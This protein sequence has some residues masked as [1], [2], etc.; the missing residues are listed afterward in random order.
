[1]QNW[2]TKLQ[3]SAWLTQKLTMLIIVASVGVAAF[4]VGRKQ[5]AQATQPGTTLVPSM[6]PQDIE[7]YSR[8]VVAYVYN[9]ISVTRAELGEYL[10]ARF[11]LERLEFLV[12]RKIVEMEC[13]Q[14]NITVTDQE[15]EARLQ[16]DL[17]SL[18]DKLTERDFVENIL[19]RFNKTLFEWKEDVIRP[20]IMM[21]KYTRKNLQV[22]EQDLKRWL[23]SPLR[24]Q[25]QMPHDRDRWQGAVDRSN[26]D[27]DTPTR[28][29]RNFS[30]KLAAIATFPISLRRKGK[31]RRSTCISATSSWSR[32]L[33][34]CK[35]AKSVT[36]LVR[37]AGQ[38]ADH[39]VM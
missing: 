11:G 26:R 29:V 21:E 25:G 31:C 14:Y 18:G 10:I 36:R 15:V 8:R 7:A 1:M 39:L 24:S 30:K 33:L 5:N 20:K 22:T 37:H 16:Q 28:G 35:K 2:L 3:P 17:R 13:R 23:R 38:L 32:P 12:N 4:L 6:S 9:D 34:Q 27:L 19:R